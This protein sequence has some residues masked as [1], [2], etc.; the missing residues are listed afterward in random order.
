MIIINCKLKQFNKKNKQFTG[1]RVI[2]PLWLYFH[3]LILSVNG[4]Q[5]T[6][7]FL[8]L[9]GIHNKDLFDCNKIYSFSFLSFSEL[10]YILSII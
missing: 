5:A 3:K 7:Y 6:L 4:M 9:L 1:I 8:N 10:M 2:V